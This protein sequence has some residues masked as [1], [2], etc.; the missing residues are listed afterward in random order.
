[1]KTWLDRT[2]RTCQSCLPFAE[3]TST[4]E[5]NFPHPKCPPSA[6]LRPMLQPSCVS[7]WLPPVAMATVSC[8]PGGTSLEL[9]TQYKQT[10]IFPEDPP[11][12]WHLVRCTQSSE[13][14]TVMASALVSLVSLSRSS[15]QSDWPTGP[16]SGHL[17][18]VD[19]T[20]I[21]R[22]S[23][24][25]ATPKLHQNLADFFSHGPALPDT[26]SIRPRGRDSPHAGRRPRAIQLYFLGLAE[27]LLRRQLSESSRE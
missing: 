10:A 11:S 20:F 5:N 25:K 15:L 1:M 24:A 13:G 19:P 18:T 4:V 6:M 2:N 17:P 8:K 16:L 3:Q 14:L 22:K 12:T 21:L 7:S 27:H 9:I 26:R 23:Y